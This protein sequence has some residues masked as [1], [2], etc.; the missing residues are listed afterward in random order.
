MNIAYHLRSE[1]LHLDACSPAATAEVLEVLHAET[2]R[3]G[4]YMPFAAN[5]L[6]HHKQAVA[7]AKLQAGFLNREFVFFIRD[8]HTGRFLGACGL[9]DRIG[10]LGRELGYWLRADA[11]G[12]GYASEA[13][14]MLCQLA[15]CQEKDV[16]RV[17]LRIEPENG[18][19]IA[20]AGRLGFVREAR[21]RRRSPWPGEEP[22][23]VVVFSLYRSQYEV[24]K[25]AEFEMQRFGPSDRSLPSRAVNEEE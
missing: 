3:L 4:R 17:E 23:D 16:D 20:V 19:S 8:R 1:R 22:R 12:K 13:V 7:F 10:P 18:E 21:L 6:P 5:I 9:H 25:L 2:E 24:S 14:T 15:F 11:I